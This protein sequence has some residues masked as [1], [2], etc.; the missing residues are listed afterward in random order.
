VF[1]WSEEHARNH[2]KQNELG[3]GVYLTL[4]Q[5]RFLAPVVQESP[6]EFARCPAR[7]D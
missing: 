5:N 2:R 3:P 7:L 1:F 4:E 6:F